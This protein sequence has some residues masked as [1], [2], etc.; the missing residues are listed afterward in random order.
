MRTERRKGEVESPWLLR[1]GFTFHGGDK[2]KGL[3][4][5]K[6]LVC[7]KEV[8]FANK[9]STVY[10]GREEGVKRRDQGGRNRFKPSIVKLVGLVRYVS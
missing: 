10:C 4:Y 7:K 2:L 3:G 8:K 5:G 9:S 1:G 6:G